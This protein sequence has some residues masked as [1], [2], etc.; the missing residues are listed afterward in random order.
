MKILRL[1]IF[2]VIVSCSSCSD[3]IITMVNT[4]PFLPNWQFCENGKNDWLPATVPGLVQ[5][6]LL[7][8][9]K[10]EEPLFDENELKLQWISETD[11]RYK[12][13]FQ[14]NDS[15]L[16]YKIVELIFKGIDTY[17]TV[18]INDSTLLKTDNMFR[19]W[20]INTRRYLKRGRNEIAVVLHAPSRMV[21]NEIKK[22]PYSLP[23]SNDGGQVKTSSFI[24]KAPYH[25]GWDWAPRF[26]T[27]GIWQPVY[28]SAHDGVYISGF[29]VKTIELADTCA[30]L[31]G[32]VT[33][34]SNYDLPNTAITI[35]DGFKQFRLK[36]GVT[37]TEVKF[38]IQNHELWWPTGMANNHCI[39]LPQSFT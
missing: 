26:L 21:A 27:M 29:Q 34:N 9:K 30:W 31:S 37:T 22:L 1:F 8:N 32:L 12:A 39:M 25:F 28:I 35:L 2:L 23:M 3:K 5:T 15:L 4:R 11:W 7:Q 38:K 20:R 6:D 36:K 33:I 17:A 10:I 13:V 24:R 18:Y 14:V 16:K 19:E